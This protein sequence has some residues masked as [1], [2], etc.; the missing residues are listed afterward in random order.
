MKDIEINGIKETIVERSDY[1]IEECKNILGNE[2]TAILGYGPQ[3]RGQGLNMRDQGFKVVLG[4]RKGRSW[5]KALADGWLEGETL[6]E[7]E[8]A[9]QRGTILQY[10]LSDAGQIAAWPVVKASLNEGDALYFS[11]GFGIVFHQDTSIIP[12]ENVDVILVAPKGSGLT[13]RTHFQEGRGINASFA[14][15][16]DYTG[17]ARERCISTAFA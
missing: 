10:L 7:T 3:G 5:D 1:P 9:A 2:V 13:V 6:F 16:Q 11:H 14:I 8:E 12:T 15:H 17:R 4:L